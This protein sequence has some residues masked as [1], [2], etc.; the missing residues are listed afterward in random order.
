L[1]DYV[2]T[3]DVEFDKTTVRYDLMQPRPFVVLEDK[4]KTIN[5]YFEGSNHEVIHIRELA[6]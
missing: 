5:D 6:E 1:Y 3:H 4:E 2:D